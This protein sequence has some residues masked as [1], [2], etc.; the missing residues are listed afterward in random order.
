MLTASGNP[1]GFPEYAGDLRTLSRRD[2]P[3]WESEKMI[4]ENIVKFFSAFPGV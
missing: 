4:L 3:W 1:E 2:Q